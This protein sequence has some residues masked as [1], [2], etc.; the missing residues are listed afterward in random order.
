MAETSSPHDAGTSTSFTGSVTLIT[1]AGNGIGRSLAGALARRGALVVVTDVDGA[2][3]ARTC[4][5][6]TAAGGAAWALTLDVTRAEHYAAARD[7]CL[8][9]WGRI[10]RVVNNAGLV[11][12][13]L[14]EN[15]PLSVWNR[16]VDVNLLGIVR[17]NE[18]FLPVLIGQGN[19]QLVNTASTSGLFPYSFDRLAYVATKAAVVAMTEALALYLRPQGIK[20]SCICP[21]GVRTTMVERMTHHGPQLPMG[22]PA[23][24]VVM[25]DDFAEHIADALAADE[26]LICSVPEAFEAVARRGA[27]LDANLDSAVEQY[28]FRPASS[29]QT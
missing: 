25:P 14:P 29:P 7:F 5:L 28:G 16:T 27:N 12:L 1:G 11:A 6:I 17:S 2:A 21:A 15:L 8:D 10:D 24:P 13:G 3:A 22:K 4:Q 19:G 9:R 18:V 20:V 26:F 23:L